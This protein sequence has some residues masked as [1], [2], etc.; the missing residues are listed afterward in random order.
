MPQKNKN[1]RNY[2][3]FIFAYQYLHITWTQFQLF[4][5]IFLWNDASLQYTSKMLDH[6]KQVFDI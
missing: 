6:D 4:I 2:Y 5:A 3:I 1:S